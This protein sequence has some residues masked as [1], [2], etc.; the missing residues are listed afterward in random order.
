MTVEEKIQQL[1]GAKDMQLAI[2]SAKVEELEAK[3][4]ELEPKEESE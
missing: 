4:K 1:L 3:L 2:L